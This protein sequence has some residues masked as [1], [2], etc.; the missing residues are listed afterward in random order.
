[1]KEKPNPLAGL[2]D[3]M[4]AHDTRLA[5]LEPTPAPVQ[6]QPAATITK[7]A[8]TPVQT[9]AT[10]KQPSRVGEKVFCAARY[11]HG[12]I[13]KIDQIIRLTHNERG[14]RLTQSDVLKKAVDRL[15]IA[16]LDEG[17]IAEILA[18]SRRKQLNS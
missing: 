6:V 8:A 1:M 15:P 4:K 5:H 18:D 11:T 16:P 13:S 7:A 3:A 14:V 9:V 12:Q 10:I 2:V 17:E